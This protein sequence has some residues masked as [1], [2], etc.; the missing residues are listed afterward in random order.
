MKIQLPGVA[1]LP[2]KP[3]ELTDLA[4]K[5]KMALDAMQAAHDGYKSKAE[6]IRAEVA[7]RYDSAAFRAIS[8]TERRRVAEV[9]T[10]GRVTETRLN[11]VAAMD[12]IAK[13]QLGP[14]IGAMN[15]SKPFYRSSADTVLRMT[16]DSERRA[17]LMGNLA[18]ATAT[19]LWHAAVTALQTADAELA[20]AIIQVVR[21]MKLDQQPFSPQEFAARFAFPPHEKAVQAINRIDR[22]AQA[23]ILLWRVV[24][25][26]RDPV[27]KIEQAIRTP[28][29]NAV[30]ADAVQLPDVAA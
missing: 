14:L 1:E 23:G 29:V 12:A 30:S 9:E 2:L 18:S 25:M 22:D 24:Q 15:R 3:G 5:A 11:A 26:G 4:V 28:Q 10:A 19:E 16:V 8:P 6:N 7:S 21:A 20:A 13:E 27:G 17:R